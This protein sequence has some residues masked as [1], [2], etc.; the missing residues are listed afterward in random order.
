V[1][2]KSRGR[3]KRRSV[4]IGLIIFIL[5]LA[6]AVFNYCR[7]L[8]LIYP[9]SNL[10]LGAIGG[11][12]LNWPSGSE[13]AVGAQGYGLLASYGKS[14]P[15]PVASVAK[16]ITA[17]AVLSKYPLQVGQPG[18]TISLTSADVALYQQYQ[19]EDGSVVEVQA[20][21]QISEYQALE[22][23]MLPSANNVADSLA[24]WAFGSLT[25]YTSFANQ[26]VTTLG[27][28]QTHIGADASGFL[29]SSTST[30]EDLVTLGLDVMKS[31][32]LVAIA[33]EKQ[34]SLP[35]V[36]VVKNV[37]WLLGEDGVIGLKTGNTDQAGGVY[38]FAADDA[39]NSSH[40]VTIIGALQG[41]ATLQTA[42]DQAVPLL[43]SVK[44]NFVLSQVIG[45]NQVIGYYQTPWRSKV[46]IVTG[47]SLTAVVWKNSLPSVKTYLKPL[48]PV[49]AAGTSVGQIGI[50]SADQLTYIPAHLS[51]TL[52]RPPFLWRLLRHNL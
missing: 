1:F 48:R 30:P 6:A 20:G 33:G 18:P 22:A 16:L 46:K 52:A 24:V 40:T 27:L 32:V 45:T 2:K 25:S 44:Q 41:L 51:G 3:R 10:Q 17:L 9:H 15:L 11:S 21:E 23:M 14:T 29:P 37:N 42:L 7:P 5:L 13:A 8:P 26:F 12:T 50:N 39:I 47:S 35:V 36:G 38:L 4:Y 43:N 34:A 19:A 28:T 49:Q 31:P